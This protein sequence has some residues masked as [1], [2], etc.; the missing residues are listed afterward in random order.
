M[1]KTGKKIIFHLKYMLATTQ[2][3]RLSYNARED[4]ANATLLPN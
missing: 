4:V 1:K 2:P 3:E